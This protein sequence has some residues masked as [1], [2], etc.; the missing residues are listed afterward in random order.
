V[1]GIDAERGVVRVGSAEGLGADG[2]E[3]VAA[4]W[5]GPIPPAGAHLAVKIRSRGAP[6][7]ARLV[8]ADRDGFALRADGGLRAVTPGQAAVLYD[9]ERVIGGGWIA[10]ALRVAGPEAARGPL[11][12][13]ESLAQQEPPR[14]RETSK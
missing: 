3:A 6:Q 9:G 4:N 2:L 5:L 12:A 7:A 14:G 13:P 8:R 1:S 10:R 11:S